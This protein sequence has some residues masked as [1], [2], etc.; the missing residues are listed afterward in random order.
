MGQPAGARPR[1]PGCGGGKG[2]ARPTDSRFC[3]VFLTRTPVQDALL[4]DLPTVVLTRTLVQ[5]VLLDDLSIVALTCAFM[6]DVL[7]DNF[8]F[9][10]AEA[11][12]EPHRGPGG[13]HPRPSTFGK[14]D[15]VFSA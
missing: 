13:T 5:D 12:S 4:D 9:S 6:Q 15:L 10:P 2:R 7:S 14:P 3:C 1:S 8:F 11:A